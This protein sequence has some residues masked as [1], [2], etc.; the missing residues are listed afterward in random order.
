MKIVKNILF[1]IVIALLILFK[2]DVGH[3]ISRIPFIISGY[4]INNNEYSKRENYKYVQITNDFDAKNKNHLKNIYYTILDSG[5]NNV[6]FTCN[7]KYPNCLNDINELS[8]NEEELSNI[9]SFVHP[10]NTFQEISTINNN[11]GVIKLVVNKA[12]KPEE[13]KKIN[14]KITKIIKE[15]EMN[16]K[17]V[18]KKAHD[19]I[20][21]ITKY[22]KKA[23]EGIKTDYKSDTAYGPLFY[24][25]ALCGGYTD[26]YYLFLDRFN[27]KQIRINSENHTWNGLFLDKPLHVDLTWDD[28]YNPEGV[29]INNYDYYLLDTDT[30]IKKEPKEHLFYQ[31]IYQEFN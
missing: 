2:N 17:N 5:D 11:L 19:Y 16:E 25:Y 31:N 9:N 1:M 12:Y 29:N 27:Y 21:K 14:Q 7:I 8:N 4:K 6:T 30:L 22:D 24:G 28:P 10:F 13:I 18:I 3:F 26:L 20:I 23:S 15:E